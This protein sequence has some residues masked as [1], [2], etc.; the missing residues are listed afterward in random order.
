MVS[1]VERQQVTLPSGTVV[2]YLVG[3]N[4][5]ATPV[6][7]LHGGGTDH[8]LLSWRDT[9]PALIAEGYRIYAPDHPGYGQSPLPKW[10]VTLEH[11]GQYVREFMIVLEIERAVFCGVS[12]GGALALGYTLAYPAGVA[13]LVLIG[14]YG[15]QDR[16][17]AHAFSYLM[18]HTPGF[19]KLNALFVGNRWL[20]KESLKQIIRNPTSLTSE[21]VEEVSDSLKNRDAQTAFRQFQRSEIR[22][23]NNKTNY[24]SVLTQITQP[25]LV[26]HGSRDIGVPLAAA[27]RAAGL[28]PHARFEV[29]KGAGHWTQRDEPERFNQLLLSFLK[30]W[31]RSDTVMD[32]SS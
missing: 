4:L 25:V 15:L 19:A 2:S 30:T 5:K 27:E 23:R 7:L 16:T 9:L 22:W 29:F 26:V 28:L 24:T 18:V 3:G 14:S 17:P 6:V 10:P 21:L 20:L 13:N 1:R 8:A 11:L 32:L 12:M 31:S